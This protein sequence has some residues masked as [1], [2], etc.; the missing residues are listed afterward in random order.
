MDPTI[1]K[2]AVGAGELKA[3]AERANWTLAHTW[4]VG[5]GLTHAGVDLGEAITYSVLAVLG[6]AWL[7]HIQRLADEEI[8]NDTRSAGS[9]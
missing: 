5:A 8:K 1:G 9:D 4:H 6:R 7:A 3:Q 2:P